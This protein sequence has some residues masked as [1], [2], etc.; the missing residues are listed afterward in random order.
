MKFAMKKCSAV[1]LALLLAV[2]L[3]PVSR[4]FAADVSENTHVEDLGNESLSANVY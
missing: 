4:G 3:L 1:L 2:S